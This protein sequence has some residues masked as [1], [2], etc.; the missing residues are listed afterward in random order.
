MEL[1]PDRVSLKNELTG[2]FTDFVSGATIAS[3]HEYSV[4]V[5]RDRPWNVSYGFICY[6]AW[7]GAAGSVS[8]ETLAGS[9]QL[10]L[11]KFEMAVTKNLSFW[12]SRRPA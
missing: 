9:C 2:F 1:G 12:S 11:N 4:R 5:V 7:G 3:L 6:G 8:A 10:G